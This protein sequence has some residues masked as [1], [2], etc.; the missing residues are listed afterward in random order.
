MKK[1]ANNKTVCAIGDVH[2][3]LQLALC[4]AARWQRELNIS[5]EA[6]LLCGD[7]GTF[8]EETQLDGTTR[9]H[10]KS[11]PCELEFLYQ[12][13]VSP[14]PGYLAKIFE[15][16]DHG[17]L[18]LECPVVMTHGNH[19]GFTHLASL[20]TKKIPG[21]LVSVSELPQVDKGNFIKY[22]PGGWKCQ[23]ISGLVIGAIGGIE[24]NQRYADYHDMAYID[25]QAV[26]HL[27]A[28]PKFDIL[29]THQ[30]PG[31]TQT[32][33]K[34]SSTLQLLLDLPGEEIAKIWFHGH[35]MVNPGIQSLGPNG[36][37][38]VVP[39]GDAAFISKGLKTGDPGDMAMCR[40]TIQKEI[41][42]ER[43]RPDFWREYRKNKWKCLDNGQLVCPDLANMI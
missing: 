5:F 10:A 27:L 40:A 35:S 41:Q 7:V 32:E 20:L 38:L 28:G 8:T 9:R 12:W 34:G 6:V 30:G 17:G 19:E 22:L 14:Q 36:S 18:G 15:P 31:S 23:T 42:Y 29:I 21:S 11:N 13:S 39:L 4:M 1:Q 43:K 3:H 26:E 24:K 25:D 16:I 37:M 2:G 33:A